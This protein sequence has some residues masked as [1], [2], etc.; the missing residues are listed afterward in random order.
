MATKKTV[1][2]K[3]RRKGGTRYGNGS[4][5]DAIENS[6]QLKKRVRLELIVC[7]SPRHVAEKLGV[8]QSTVAKWRTEFLQDPEFNAAIEDYNQRLMSEA[9]ASFQLGLKRAEDVANT[10]TN[11][12]ARAAAARVLTSA[13]ADLARA[14][15]SFE[16]KLS[17][18]VTLDSIDELKKR[19]GDGS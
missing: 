1:K 3:Q 17:G 8:P 11:D 2:G 19:L 7:P 14:R 13:P 12:N 15:N 16:V 6:A 9:L 18:Q 5:T 4:V 10:S